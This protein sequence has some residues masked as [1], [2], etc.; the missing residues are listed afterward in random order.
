LSGELLCGRSAF[1]VMHGSMH[2]A[3]GDGALFFFSGDKPCVC[4]DLSWTGCSAQAVFFFLSGEQLCEIS[5]FNK[6]KCS[7]HKLKPGALF[8][9][10]GDLLWGAEGFDKLACSLQEFKAGTLDFLSGELLCETTEGIQNSRRELALMPGVGH[11][12][13]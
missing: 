6:P 7:P 2:K 10:S 4:S 8:F 9:F 12:L 13:S 5:L 1:D 11:L 3:N